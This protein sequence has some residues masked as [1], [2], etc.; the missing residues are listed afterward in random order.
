MYAI[1]NPIE[2][3]LVVIWTYRTKDDSWYIFDKDRIAT[4]TEE[5]ANAIA[6]NYPK[7]KVIPSTQA[8]N[9]Y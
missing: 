7:A 5:E 3:G 9:L 8:G 2:F 4:Y 6:Q 1:A